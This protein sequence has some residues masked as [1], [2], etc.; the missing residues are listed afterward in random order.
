MR[1][2]ASLSLQLETVSVESG[3][4]WRAVTVRSFKWSSVMR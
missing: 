1:V 3:C 2:M 4:Y